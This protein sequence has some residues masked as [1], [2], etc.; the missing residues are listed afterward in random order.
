MDYGEIFLE[1]AQTLI[2]AAISSIEMDQTVICTIEDISERTS[3]K[4]IVSSGETS[5]F[6]A[7]S[8]D[9]TYH[10]KDQVYVL[11]PR[12]DTMQRL[13]LSKYITEEA[14]AITYVSQRDKMVPMS[15]DL[16]VLGTNNYQLTPNGG[17]E[18]RWIELKKVENYNKLYE[19][20]IHNTVYLKA[21]FKCPFNGY[22]I[23]EGNYGLLLV[24]KNDEQI[25]TMTLDSS[26]MFGNPFSFGGYFLQEK[27]FNYKADND[28]T[29]LELYF[30]QDNNFKYR[31][32]ETGQ[33]LTLDSSIANI[34][35][36]NIE[37]FFGYN[38]ENVE[39]DTVKIFTSS[40]ILY[41]TG[42]MNKAISLVWY[43]K[44]KDNKYLGFTDGQ[45][46]SREKATTAKEANSTDENNYYWIDW[47]V[48][49][50][51]GALE[52]ISDG[53]SSAK[54]Y[55]ATCLDVL[56]STRVQAY[57][58]LNGTAYKSNIL[59]FENQRLKSDRVSHDNITLELEHGEY[60]QNLY[61]LYG[62]NNAL[63]DNSQA[64]RDRK[65][66]LKWSS[67]EGVVNNTY[68]ENAT[69]LWYL[70][71]NATM[72]APTNTSGDISTDQDTDYIFQTRLGSQG[73]LGEDQKTFTY[74]IKNLYQRNFVNNTIKCAIELPNGAGRAETSITFAF[75]SSGNSGTSYTLAVTPVGRAFGKIDTDAVLDDFAVSLT[76]AEGES[77]TETASF[78]WEK[79][80]VTQGNIAQNGSV[81]HFAFDATSYNVLKVS[82]Q[83]EWAGMD[84]NLDTLYA[85]EYS[86]EG[87]YY[88]SAMNHI[89]Y[90]SFGKLVNTDF[91]ELE[92]FELDTN[93]KVSGV[94][95]RIAYRINSSSTEDVIPN[96][97]ILSWLPQMDE[98][99]NS[100]KPAMMYSADL[101][102]YCVLIAEKG[103][104]IVYTTPLIIEQYQYGSSLLNNWDG[105]L[106]IDEENNTILAAMMGAG[107]KNDDNTF[108]GVVM[109]QLQKV[110]G[111]IKSDITGLIGYHHG[112]QSF[113][114]KDDG[115]AFIGKSGRGRIEFDGNA[116][117]ISSQNWTYD[118]I[119]E[120]S[121]VTGY[122]NYRLQ[123][124][125][126][127][128]SLWNLANGDL[129]L[130]K[131]SDQYLK[132]IDNGLYV[133]TDNIYL[134]NG[135]QLGIHINNVKNEIT[136][137][138]RKKADYSATSSGSGKNTESN[139][140]TYWDVQFSGTVP[141][142]DVLFTDGTTLL[143]KF[144][145]A[146]KE[147][148]Q[149]RL[150]FYSDQGFNDVYGYLIYTNGKKVS[151]DNPL[152]WDKDTEIFFIFVNDNGTK[153]WNATDGSIYSK[154]T[155][156]AEEIRLKVS[157]LDG[158]VR[159]LESNTKG[160]TATAITRTGNGFNW[161]LDNSS[162]T[163]NT[164]KNNAETAVFKCTNA[165][166]EVT[167]TIY[168]N[169]GQ[170]ARW[171]ISSDYLQAG[172][173]DGNK[174]GMS[175]T[176][177]DW[178]FWA[179]Y[180]GSTGKAPFRITH[181]GALYATSGEI[182][183][184]TINSNSLKTGTAGSENGILF[185]NSSLGSALKVGGTSTTNWRLT[186][187]NNFGV[188]A[189]G[190]L[191]CSGLYCSGGTIYSD[192]EI[193]GSIGSS[194]SYADHV[195]GE[196]VG[197]SNGA[198]TNYFTTDELRA[199]TVIINHNTLGL[200]QLAF[201]T[202]G[203]VQWVKSSG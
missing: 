175:A 176:Q 84:I 18:D 60:S 186:I 200:I 107:I 17:D 99:K 69:V 179:G 45:F 135:E 120:N 116:G 85:V 20:S 180:N 101:G 50:N 11:I 70:P 154:I 15:E 190:N 142:N 24:F 136:S 197:M 182:G 138:V 77:L 62:E 105:S 48:D 134:G 108:S 137:E 152:I 12:D 126:T 47:F 124:G 26:D 42:N 80:P 74:R 191:Y 71:K 150:N 184:W 118:K 54:K 131:D 68:W 27:I 75:S 76:N 37:V 167:G 114:F 157:T 104:E 97:T 177:T 86:K 121:I 31:D 148:E 102:Y 28:F 193:Y 163:L 201:G 10:L 14:Q 78:A 162:F 170:I 145:K 44:D 2:D 63:V 82:T 66:K 100:I 95:W 158:N 96:A 88:S 43:N 1:S 52:K 187:G 106:Q 198:C 183:G 139:N 87:K 49:N 56:T 156:T 65:I 83:Q 174:V 189:K 53:N 123:N 57:V 79:Y 172:G 22:T 4:Y 103:G 98:T 160:I 89:I 94:Y 151:K 16:V 36:K 192:V 55:T 188:T 164:I 122:N 181:E 73:F 19:S 29:D 133:Q 130:Q 113:G 117:I 35:V 59:T 146:Q 168:A 128:G 199:N 165:G 40:D 111:G 147:K 30:Y 81:A 3:G 9:K 203:T 61:S 171:N 33:I 125:Q 149:L 92:L 169:K 202:G 64:Y 46:L 25:L 173:T 127:R 132:F 90:N 109:G 39:D 93:K 6:E 34:E 8:E 166:I 155:Q 141:S 112:A 140:I 119:V 196:W 110:D 67:N 194:S 129:I 115:T 38:A 91:P 153:Y 159:T 41:G 21:E 144:T 5:S 23:T 185:T 51:T 72:L 58:W 143:V 195:Y 7:Y 161:K 13:I 178:A 32:A